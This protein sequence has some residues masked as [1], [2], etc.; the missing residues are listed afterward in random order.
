M[1]RN[2]SLNW[3]VPNG[4]ERLTAGFPHNPQ[5]DDIV[6]SARISAPRAVVRHEL[7][8][9][10]VV[11]EEGILGLANYLELHAYLFPDRSRATVKRWLGAQLARSFGG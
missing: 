4:E 3:L 5:G 10:E 2:P 9:T 11:D 6:V 1:T 8:R 7:V